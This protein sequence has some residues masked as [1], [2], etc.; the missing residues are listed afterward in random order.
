[1]VVAVVVALVLE[2][3]GEEPLQQ[4]AGPEIDVAAVLVVALLVMEPLILAA[5]VVVLEPAVALV[6]P[7]L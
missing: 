3:L 2:P 4:V 1:V 7:A 5:V 6:V